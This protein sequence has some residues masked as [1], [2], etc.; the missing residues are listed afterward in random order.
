LIR[1]ASPNVLLVQP[2]FNPNAFWNYHETCA[3]AGARYSA[4]PLGLVTVAGLLPP[5]WSPRLVDRNIEELRDDD[6]DWADLVMVGCMMPQQQ[7]AKRVI[8][9]AQARGKPVVIGGPDVTSSPDVYDEVEFRVLGEAEAIMADFVAAW[10]TGA[11]EGDF[12]ATEFPDLRTSPLPRFDLLKLR[13]YLHVGV[14]FSRGCPYQ[15]EFCNVIELNGR[16]PRFKTT[17]Q[18]LREL[19]ALHAL[20]YR[21][22]VDFVDD[23]LIGNAKGVQP[24]LEAL[25]DWGEA[26]GHP[27][28]YSTE[29]SLN[30]ADRDDLLA[31][32]RRAGFFAVFVGI[33]TPDKAALMGAR[34]IQNVQRDIVASVHKIYRAGMYVNA[35]FILG[36]D[37]ESSDVA[38]QMMGCIEDAAIPMCMVGLLYALP[39]T[40]LS[41]RLDTEGRLHADSDRLVG[42]GDADQCTSGLNFDTTRPRGDILADYRSI[43]SRTNAPAAFFGRVRR[44]NRQLDLSGHR[45]RRPFGSTGRDLRTF[46]RITWQL[47]VRDREVRGEFWRTLADSLFHRPRTL[48]GA[49]SFAALYLHVKSFSRFMDERLRA[50]L[51]TLVTPEIP[52]TARCTNTREAIARA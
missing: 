52:T 17:A 33:E 2:R 20:G 18:M 13:H 31:V 19:D 7:D 16:V 39:S 42:A 35:G 47:G 24:F 48:R 15:C 23:N 37:A 32:M 10:R 3:V 29:A 26:H 8:A 14:Q 21:G 12:V 43:L 41:R 5:D 50:Q 40:R 28:E 22:H 25:A 44:L 11:A 49:M 27:F 38:R 36:F 51:E 46:A 30:L 45:L 34:K 1:T 6:L 9:L 4:A